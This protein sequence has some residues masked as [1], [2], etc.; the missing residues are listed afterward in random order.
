[1]QTAICH[2]SFHRTWKEE[3]WDCVTLADA[4]KATGA[5]GIDFHAGLLGDHVKA[6]ERISQALDRTG[7]SL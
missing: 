6:G 3:Q 4:I 7:L 2:Y 1:M 5:A